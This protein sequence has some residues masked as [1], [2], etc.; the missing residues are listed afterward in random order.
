M[1]ALVIMGVITSQLFVMLNA[2]Q[3]GFRGTSRTLDLQESTR[4]VSDLIAFDTRNGGMLVPRETAVS[5]DDGGANGPDRLCVSDGTFFP[6]PAPGV[7]DTFWDNLGD[8][9]PGASVVTSGS[10]NDVVVD[11]LDIDGQGG[12]VDFTVGAGLI[13]ASPVGTTSHCA[14]ITGIDTATRMIR[15][16]Q[17]APFSPNG[18]IVVPAIVYRIDP[19]TTLIRRND[20]VLS[21]NVQDLQVEFWV[22]NRGSPNGLEDADEFPVHDLT[23]ATSFVI[24]TARIRRVQISIVGISDQADDARGIT[25][26]RFTRPRVAN[27]TDVVTSDRTYQL[28]VTS[29][30]PRNILDPGAI[31]GVP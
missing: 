28:F 11:S 7:V 14:V 26:D 15:F 24:N 18:A 21:N 30:L 20:M 13:I 19:G 12:L 31:A 25:A 9:F 29:V 22:D 16:E 8:R 27:R 1:I 23:A 6:I 10:T 2:Q 17:S 3:R 5:S 4:L